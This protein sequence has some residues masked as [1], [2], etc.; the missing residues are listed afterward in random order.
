MAPISGHPMLHVLLQRLK[1]TRLPLIVATSDEPADEAVADVAAGVQ[2]PVVQGSEHDVLARFARAVRSSES[3][4]AVRVTADCPL[5]D[6]QIVLATI[7][8]LQESGADYVSNTLVRTWPDG[9]DVEAV[10][11]PVLLHAAETAT[12][13]EEREHVTPFI[14]RR[15]EQFSLRT[16]RGPHLLGRERWTVDT[17]EDLAF[18]RRIFDHFAPRIDFT[19]QETLSFLGRPANTKH[20]HLRPATENDEALILEWRNDPLAIRMSLTTNAVGREEHSRWFQSVL[21]KPSRRLWIAEKQGEGVGQ[22]RIDVREAAGEVALTVAPEHRGQG[23]GKQILDLLKEEL[24]ND[25]QVTLLVAR[26]RGSNKASL[27]TFTSAGFEV[28]DS[29]GEIVQLQW[30]R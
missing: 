14:Y 7:R 4:I 5:I 1:L 18:I 20:L 22:V 28:V 10:R 2:V 21:V 23:M 15:P 24:R 19:W 6:P 3:D 12:A 30:V 8:L 9:L 13:L 16:L 17:P 27:R 26:V 25:F 11:S 29:A